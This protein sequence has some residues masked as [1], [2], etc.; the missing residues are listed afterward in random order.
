MLHTPLALNS[1]TAAQVL[2]DQLVVNGVEHVF[3]VP[4][5]SFLAVLDALYDTRHHGHGLPPGRRRRHDGRS[6][7]QGDRAGRASAS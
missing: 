5:E 3:C 2:V 4:G 6:G 1:R 7:R